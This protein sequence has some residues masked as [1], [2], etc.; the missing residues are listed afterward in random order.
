LP[1]TNLYIS[2]FQGGMPSINW[3]ASTSPDVD[4]YE[5]WWNEVVG[6][7]YGWQL[8]ATTSATSWVDSRVTIDSYSPEDEYGY[9]ALTVDLIGLK[10]GFSNAAYVLVDECPPWLCKQLAG[11]LEAIPEVYALGNNYPNPFNPSTTIQYGLPQASRVRLTIYDLMGKKVYAHS[12]VEEAGYWQ[13]K[14][15]GKNHSGQAVPSG[16]YIYRLVAISTANGSHF[17]ATR[18]MLL[19]K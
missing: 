10:S 17:T 11:E 4:H 2:G 1:P 18:K 19:L 8:L 6:P 12:A 7:P 13:M 15:Q 3:T 5:L 9:K 14:W 16:V